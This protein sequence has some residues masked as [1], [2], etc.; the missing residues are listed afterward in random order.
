M[1]LGVPELEVTSAGGQP[2]GHP[3]LQTQYPSDGS[4]AHDVPPSQSDES[5]HR[6]CAVWQ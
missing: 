2:S 1:T 4:R 5:T 6:S 3:L